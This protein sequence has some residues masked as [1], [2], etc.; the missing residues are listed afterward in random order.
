MSR[1]G[2]TK[3][4]KT[5][6]TISESVAFNADNVTAFYGIHHGTFVQCPGASNKGD[7][8]EQSENLHPENSLRS[9]GAFPIYSKKW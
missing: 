4:Q 6:L 1:E 8:N 3:L 5:I 2:L 9:T 7:Q